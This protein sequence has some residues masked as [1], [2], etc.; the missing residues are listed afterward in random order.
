MRR[1]PGERVNACPNLILPDKA[2]S[3]DP[4]R[5]ARSSLR[6]LGVLGFVSLAGSY[7]SGKIQSVGAKSAGDA[8][9]AQNSATRP[10]GAEVAESSPPRG[11]KAVFPVGS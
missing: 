2:E 10:A 9:A 11:V 1:A 3:V 5:A 8:W 6:T 7:L 4:G